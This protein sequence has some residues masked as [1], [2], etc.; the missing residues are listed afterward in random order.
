MI[1]LMGSPGSGKSTQG[2][3]LT[4][5]KKLRWIS[6][7]DILRRNASQKYLKKMQAGE[8]FSGQ[9]V[10]KAL[11]NELTKLGDKPELILDGFPRSQDQVEWLLVQTTQ[12]KITVSAVINIIVDKKTAEER[13]LKRGRVDDELSK[14]DK[15]LKIYEQTYAP[16]F[17]ALKAHHIHILEINGNQNPQKIHRDILQA[18]DNLGIE[19]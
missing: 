4:D 13:L 11:S 2:Q 14:I 12:G 7:S 5:R 3:L 10:F 9:V 18:L 8:L 19:A 17:Q 6:M 1:I 16:I 15:R